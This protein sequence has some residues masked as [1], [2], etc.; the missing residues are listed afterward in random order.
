MRL[1]G[2][3]EGSD[4]VVLHTRALEQQPLEAR[5]QRCQREQMVAAKVRTVREIQTLQARKPRDETSNQRWI[6]PAGLRESVKVQLPHGLA[7]H[8]L[9]SLADGREPHRLEGV[10]VAAEEAVADEVVGQH[11]VEDGKRRRWPPRLLGQA[12]Q[13]VLRQELVAEHVVEDVGR[14]RLSRRLLGLSLRMLP[15]SLRR[16]IPR[17]LTGAGGPSGLGRCRRCHCCCSC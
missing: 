4:V 7:R 17:R 3:E 8:G 2:S 10:E 12:V 11:G 1:A 6:E 5:R 13:M 15:L 9:E 14:R 16:P